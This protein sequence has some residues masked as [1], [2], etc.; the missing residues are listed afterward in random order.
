MK[1]SLEKYKVKTT[2][3]DP[4]V[5]KHKVALSYGYQVLK[6]LP[7]NQKFDL[8]ICAVAHNLFKNFTIENWESLIKKGGMMVDFKGIIPRELNPFRI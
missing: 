7:N 4:L 8:L 1:I 5:D 2:I 6:E 3:Y